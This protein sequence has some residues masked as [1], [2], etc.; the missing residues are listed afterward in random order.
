M[1]SNPQRCRQRQ[2]RRHANHSP[3]G[4]KPRRHGSLGKVLLVP[5]GMLAAATVVVLAWQGRVYLQGEEKTSFITETVKRG[6]LEITITERGSLE[7][8]NNKTLVCEVEGEAGTGILKIVDEGSRVKEGDELVLLDASKLRNDATAQEIVVEQA[9][10]THETALKNVEIQI[11]QNDSDIAAAELKWKLARLD[12]TKYEEGDYVQE[13]NTIQ[14]E[15]ELAQEDYTRAKD[16]YAFTQR[17]INKGYAKRSEVEADRVA[18]YFSSRRR[19]TSCLSD[20]SS[21]VCSSD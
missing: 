15:I 10:A 2:R 8:A 11:T 17:L 1:P 19:H 5:L 18:F 9:N 14:G 4:E 12:L 21:D 6:A 7:S 13:K 16:K 3:I 20:W